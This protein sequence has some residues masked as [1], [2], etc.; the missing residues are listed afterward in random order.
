ML[1][2]YIKL[3]WRSI[4]RNKSFSFINIVGLTGGLTCFLLIA[5][6]IVDESTFDA[7]HENADRIYRV[8]EQRTSP[9]GKEAKLGSTAYQVSIS[10]KAD[11]PEVEQA[12]RLV[13]LGRVNV[14]TDENTSVFYDEFWLSNADFLR[15]FSFKLLQGNRETALS[16]PHS[17]VVTEET[18]RKLFNTTAVL[19]KTIRVNQDS[20]PY[21]ITGVLKNFPANSQ[22]SFN[23]L[24]SE[25]T[26][27]THP[28]FQENI[29]SDW[30]SDDFYTYLLLD[31]QASPKTVDGLCSPAHLATVDIDHQQL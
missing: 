2:N 24:F 14:G 27:T 1:K 11:F 22:L 18:A 15:S 28:D 30:D 29:N 4:R 10:S 6:Y 23:L 19:G 3:A 8:V 17:V 13:V 21:Q 12:V 5:L 31:K 20:T 26:I 25:S 16:A 9:D 7:F